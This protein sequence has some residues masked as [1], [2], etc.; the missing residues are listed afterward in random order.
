MPK[1]NLVNIPSSDVAEAI[2]EELNRLPADK[3]VLLLLAG[4]SAVEMEVELARLLDNPSNIT[5]SLTDERFVPIAHPDSNW[6]KLAEVGFDFSKFGSTYPVVNGQDVA[7]TTIDFNN[8]LQSKIA[9]GS[10]CV[11]VFGMG[12]DGHTSGILPGSL[13]VKSDDY[14]ASYQGDDFLRITTTPA[15]IAKMNEA[16]LFAY[17]DNKHSQINRLLKYDLSIA[18]QPVQIMKQ[19]A[20]VTIFS[21]YK[22]GQ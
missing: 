14:A 6:A 1:I 21:D 4:G 18:D 10:Y 12:A 8:F 16:F 22:G 19:V 7:K 17:G 11:G 5:L 3:K 9:D 15:F 2:A 20:R 13:S